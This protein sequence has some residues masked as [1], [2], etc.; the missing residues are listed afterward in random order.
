MEQIP[1]TSHGVELC[2]RLQISTLEVAA[3]RTVLTMPVT[4]NRQLVGLLHGGGTAALCETAGSLAALAHARQLDPKLVA[5]GTELNISHLR[6]V[7]EGT[8]TATATALHLGRTRT[9]HRVEV[10][11]QDDGLVAS[12]QVTNLIVTPRG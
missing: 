11:D 2:D 12:A 8:V 5:V 1:L 7:S 9:V 3:Q 4:G 6:S 10:H